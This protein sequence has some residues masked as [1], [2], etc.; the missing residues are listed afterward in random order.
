M[1]MTVTSLEIKLITIERFSQA[2]DEPLYRL[3]RGLYIAQSETGV[4]S[5]DNS[6]G[7]MWCEE[8]DDEAAAK[9]WLEREE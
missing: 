6:T 7:Q 2:I 4:V 3:E 8:F 9:A 5:V 1:L